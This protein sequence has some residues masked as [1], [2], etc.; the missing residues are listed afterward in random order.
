MARGSGSPGQR[1]VARKGNNVHYRSCSQHGG[2]ASNVHVLEYLERGPVPSCEVC[3]GGENLR[4]WEKRQAGRVLPTDAPASTVERLSGSS[5]GRREASGLRSTKSAKTTKTRPVFPG[6]LTRST[7]DATTDW[8]DIRKNGHWHFV[9]FRVSLNGSKVSSPRITTT[10]TTPQ[11][12][13]HWLSPLLP[14]KFE[15]ST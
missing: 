4:S 12:Y 1:A 15:I 13:F 9:Y 5:A 10:T 8:K 2:Q 7:H 6:A 14:P 11:H 3:Y